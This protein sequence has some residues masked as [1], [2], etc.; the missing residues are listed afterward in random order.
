MAASTVAVKAFDGSKR[1]ELHP[2]TIVRWL[3]HISTPV[4]QAAIDAAMAD[5]LPEVS[6]LQEGR[7]V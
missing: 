5:W 3:A 6:D 7:A 4:P 2:L 1:V